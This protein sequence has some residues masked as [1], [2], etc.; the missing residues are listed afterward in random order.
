[1]HFNTKLILPKFPQFDKFV[2]SQSRLSML[3]SRMIVFI[4]C[5]GRKLERNTFLYLLTANA[6]CVPKPF[7]NW[8]VEVLGSKSGQRRVVF[9]IIYFLVFHLGLFFLFEKRLHAT[10][11]TYLFYK[12]YGRL[13]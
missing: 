5:T 4:F 11:V 9:Y 8:F 3:V 12:F 2:T 1:M 6:I 7:L 10:K 13:N